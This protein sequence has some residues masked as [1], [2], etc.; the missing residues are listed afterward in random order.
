MNAQSGVTP[1]ALKENGLNGAAV[2]AGAVAWDPISSGYID[3]STFAE[4]DEALPS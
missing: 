2:P 4:R 3:V 1:L